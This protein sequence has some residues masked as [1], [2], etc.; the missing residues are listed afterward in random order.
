MNRIE[1]LLCILGL[2]TLSWV[3]S[4]CFRM[5]GLR[6]ER[7]SEHETLRTIFGYAYIAF[8]IFGFPV[9]IFIY[10]RDTKASN[11]RWDV[12]RHTWRAA[13]D[14]LEYK[15][16]SQDNFLYREDS[17]WDEINQKYRKVLYLAG[18]E[19]EDESFLAYKDYRWNRAPTYVE[20]HLIEDLNDAIEEYDAHLGQTVKKWTAQCKESF[21]DQLHYY[22]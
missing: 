15:R 22:K 1:S 14:F 2:C 12:K 3:L 13:R 6:L 7:K 19:D 4:D 10:F 21:A 18:L 8:L 17:I 5:L 20:L 9:S 11:R 16:I